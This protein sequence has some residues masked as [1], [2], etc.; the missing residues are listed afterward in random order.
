[1]KRKKGPVEFPIRGRPL[2]NPNPN[3][4]PYNPNVLYTKPKE[5]SVVFG[6]SPDR[7]FE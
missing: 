1:M 2:H 3:D 4:A 7:F 6:K 5:V